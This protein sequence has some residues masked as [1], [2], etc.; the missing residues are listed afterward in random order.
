[1]SLCVRVCVCVCVCARVCV[2]VCACMCE[3]VRACVRACARVCMCVCVCVRETLFRLTV[4]FTLFFAH[5]IG[6]RV[7]GTSGFIECMGQETLKHLNYLQKPL[8][9]VNKPEVWKR[10][11]ISRSD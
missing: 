6:R 7:Q 4:I 8:D 9:S 3:C 11:V 5:K 10:K 1:M 2:C